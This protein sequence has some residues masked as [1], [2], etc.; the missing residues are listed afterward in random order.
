MA[1]GSSEEWAVR[2]EETDRLCGVGGTL[3][4]QGFFRYCEGRWN[5][6]FRRDVE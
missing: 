1:G 4:M 2:S 6:G 3:A 5:D